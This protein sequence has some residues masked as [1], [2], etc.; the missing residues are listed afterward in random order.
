MTKILENRNFMKCPSFKEEMAK[1]DQQNGVAPPPVNIAP[2]GGERI[3]LP[4]FDGVV[5][6]DSYTNLLD[7]RR[8]VRQYDDAKPMTAAQLAY[9]LHTAMS[10]QEFRGVENYAT[11]RPA[12]SGGARHP[13][14]LY[15]AVQ[16]VEGVPAGLYHYLPME[17]VGKKAATIERVGDIASHKQ[18][19]TDML[20]GQKWAENASVTLFITCV[21]YRAEWRYREN[22]HRVIL[23]DLGHVGQ[24]IMLSA[25]ALG[26]GS[27]C[28]AAYDQAECDKVL[29]VDGVD[30]YTVYG[31]TV[32][33][34]K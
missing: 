4:S 23:I 31:V 11:L 33:V 2:L 5:T 27:C 25:A 30:E 18:T 6:N 21:A 17:D 28:L 16:N 1:S 8:S 29:M 26:L 32:G 7:V 12:P 22:A 9:V 20:V 14:E 15:V 13:F 10:I 3:A 19:V 24:N 34:V